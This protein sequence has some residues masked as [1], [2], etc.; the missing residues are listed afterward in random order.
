[1][2]WS[3]VVV[4][5]LIVLGAGVLVR[6]L[7]PG[8]Y[9]WLALAGLIGFLV[10]QLIT[11]L[12]RREEPPA[13]PGWEFHPSPRLA[14][15]RAGR[16]FA[17]ATIMVLTILFAAPDPVP[18][19]AAAFAAAVSLGIGVR[20]V[21]RLVRHTPALRLSATGIEVRGARYAWDRIGGV[22]LNGD[23]EHP[24]LDVLVSGRRRSVTLRPSSVD[25]SL[26]F[27][28]D[29]IGYHQ[30]HP[31]RRTAIGQAEEAR[32]VHELLLSARLAAGLRGGPGPIVTG[33]SRVADG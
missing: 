13:R 25:A 28:M 11:D 21:T 14:S 3:W 32:R 10:N 20:L 6:A 17:V 15:A 2:R 1:M 12:R 23:R 7:A 22:E 29:L 24:R 26:L 4:P 27:L 9:L 16:A 33:P 19:G 5:S 31:E 18:V 8:G 30:S